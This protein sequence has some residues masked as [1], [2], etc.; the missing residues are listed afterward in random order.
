MIAF[1]GDAITCWFDGDN[2]YRAT[3][4]ALAMQEAMRPFA[5]LTTPGGASISPDNEGGRGDRTGAALSRRRPGR[6]RAGRAGRRT[7]VRLAAA[8]TSG[9]QR[10]GDRR[11]PR[12]WLRSTTPSSAT[13]MT[14]KRVRSSPSSQR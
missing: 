8:E 4:S 9:R 3:T 10:R 5:A 11:Y 2:G 13:V 12:R 6:A 14:Q 7:L 1:A